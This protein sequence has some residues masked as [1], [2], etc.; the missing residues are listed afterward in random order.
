MGT[1]GDDVTR[2]SYTSTLD[3]WAPAISPNGLDIA[4]VSGT[5]GSNIYLT[6]V[7]GELPVR[8]NNANE[9][10][11]VQFA[12]T[13]TLYYLSNKGENSGITEFQLWKINTDS[14][15]ETRAFTNEFT[16]WALGS[17]DF[18]IN[19][20][21]KNVYLSSFTSSY[22]KSFIQYGG[23]GDSCIQGLLIYD[24][25]LGDRY[26]PELSVDGTKIAF[27]AD[28]SGGNHRLYSDDAVPGGANP[29]LICDTFCGSPS[30]IDNNSI[31]FT[32]AAQSTFGLT[33]YTGD[34]W[35]VDYSGSNLKKLTSL[36]SCAYPSVY[37]EI[38][39]PGYLLFIICNLILVHRRKFILIH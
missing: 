25:S 4:F 15:A 29:T 21:N 24:T 5:G 28:Y 35:R 9:A 12:T 11:C 3:E 39:E 2:I 1:N 26:A 37:E 36:G 30:W 18:S 32:R 8:L 16:C 13:N 27:C 7:M 6:S 33:A 22:S 10:L 34:I 23:V 19:Q 31:V 38:P 20:A 17:L 14:S